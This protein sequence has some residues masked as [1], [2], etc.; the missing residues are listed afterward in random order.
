VA[1]LRYI[2]RPREEGEPEADVL[3]KQQRAENERLKAEERQTKRDKTRGEL[4]ER[5]ACLRQ[6]NYVMTAIRQRLLLVPALAAR[7]I[8]ADDQHAAKLAIDLEIRKALEELA[9]FPD[10]VTDGGEWERTR[11]EPRRTCSGGASPALTF[12]LL[13][14]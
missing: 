11:K 6:A 14:L 13:R 3:Y 4:I 1:N 12:V 5:S 2:P 7:K 8:K 9:D 10:K